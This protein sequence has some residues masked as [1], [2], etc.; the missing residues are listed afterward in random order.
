M[1]AHRHLPAVSPSPTPYSSLK[2]KAPYGDVQEEEDEDGDALWGTVKI[3]DAD[4]DAD[5][6]RTQMQTPI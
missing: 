3:V 2:R 1:P 5:A 4:A 6:D